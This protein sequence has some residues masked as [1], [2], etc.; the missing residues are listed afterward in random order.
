MACSLVWHVCTILKK[1]YHLAKEHDEKVRVVP[2]ELTKCLSAFG[3]LVYWVSI[4]DSYHVN[5]NPMLH[6]F[7]W[8]VH[9]ALIQMVGAATAGEVVFFDVDKL[10]V[11]PMHR[12]SLQS[13]EQQ[14]R[15]ELEEL[16]SGM[17]SWI[18]KQDL[19]KVQ[20]LDRITSAVI[21][22]L[23]DFSS[24]LETVEPWSLPV[25]MQRAF[26]QIANKVDEKKKAV[27]S[28]PPTL[29]MRNTHGRMARGHLNAIPPDDDS[30]NGNV[31]DSEE[32]SQELIEDPPEEERPSE[33]AIAKRYL[34]FLSHILILV[35]FGMIFQ[36]L[37]FLKFDVMSWQLVI[38]KVSNRL[39]SESFH[40]FLPGNELLDEDL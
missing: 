26:G 3:T 25:F 12:Q 36:N 28:M 9:D 29:Q 39:I 7:A 6:S 10:V 21:M 40:L 4:R 35:W 19:L 37:C 8:E 23:S 32:E 33:S 22:G 30:E 18:V 27:T 16:P 2:E 1:Y 11:P 14:L 17:A 20:H 13:E 24:A 38:I 34:V 5:A 31:E 15:W